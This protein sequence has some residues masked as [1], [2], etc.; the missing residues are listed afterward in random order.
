LL[1]FLPRKA[2]EAWRRLTGVVPDP[3]SAWTTLAT[4]GIPADRALELGPPLFPR[5]EEP[6]PAAE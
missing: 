5:I 4:A 3:R 1:P 2:S 6:P